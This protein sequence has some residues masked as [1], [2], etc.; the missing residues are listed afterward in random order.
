MLQ[1]ASDEVEGYS[2][3]A[4]ARPGLARGGE[5]VD[6]HADVTNMLEGLVIKKKSNKKCEKQVG[7]GMEVY[8]AEL[9]MLWRLSW[10]WQLGRYRP[11]QH[12]RLLYL[13]CS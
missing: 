10:A 1:S 3:T 12:G 4:S 2:L 11:G 7:D 6:A 13:G 8:A 5:R 9:H